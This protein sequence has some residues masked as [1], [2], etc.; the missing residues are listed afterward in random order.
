MKPSDLSEAISILLPTRRPIYVWGPPGVGKSCIVHQA[1]ARLGYAV[2]DLRAVLLDPVDLRG[3]P[4][5]NKELR[6]AEWFP[7]EFLPRDDEEIGDTKGLLFLDE[8]AQSPPL[9]QAACLQLTLDRKVGD[10]VLPPNW[11]V[12][13]ASNRSEDRAG[14]HRLITPLLNRFIHLDL[15]VSHEEWNQWAIDANIAPEVRAFINFRPGLLHQFDPST[16]ERAFP[17]PRSWE[18]ASDA[19]K[20]TPAHLLHSIASG[21]VGAGPAAEFCAFVKT[22]RDLP[23]VDALIAEPNQYRPITDPCILYALAGAVAERA[24]GA[25]AKKLN[26][27][28][29]LADKLPPEF[30]ILTVRD[31]SQIN[32]GILD[33]RAVPAAGAWLKKNRNVLAPEYLRG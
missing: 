20:V 12:I 28:V 33:T 2:C 31:A 17:T 9:V 18:F 27:M 25:E 15:E 19:V 32:R 11:V 23:D 22:Y 26:N 30:G 7:P 24:R 1:A 4:S 8:L 29:L 13:A 5:V 21:I 6:R 3:L 10:Y 16:G 14:A